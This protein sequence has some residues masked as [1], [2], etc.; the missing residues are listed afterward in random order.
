MEIF[1]SARRRLAAWEEQRPAQPSSEPDEPL[2]HEL[3]EPFRRLE[4]SGAPGFRAGLAGPLL[5]ELARQLAPPKH[6]FP[7]EEVH[8]AAP[9]LPDMVPPLE[10]I[11]VA[12]AG[13]RVRLRLDQAIAVRAW[14][15]GFEGGEP[16]LPEHL[17][18]RWR[19]L[20]LQRFGG[21][22]GFL[23]RMR[24][25][26]ASR[27]P[28]LVP[29]EIGGAFEQLVL[30]ILNEDAPLAHHASFEEDLYEKTDLR[31]KL[32]NLDR[33]R[34]ARVQVTLMSEPE[35]L[36]EK[37]RRIPRVRELVVLSPLTLAQAAIWQS[38]TKLLPKDE[39]AAFWACAPRGTEPLPL[40]R[41]LKQRLLAATTAPAAPEGPRAH[42]PEPI[43]RLLR[44][45]VANEATRSSAEMRE[46]MAS[47]RPRPPGSTDG[48]EG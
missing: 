42:V 40:A 12:H 11:T 9:A 21:G 2:P 10:A 32:P 33:R 22:L 48:G 35:K 14:S 23:A 34:G 20:V 45:Y 13:R 25:P 24:P 27:T 18:A 39:A 44:R 3:E 17:D 16:G 6:L 37:L 1:E 36:G 7:I 8:R 46:R 43:R 47:A 5:E 41:F 29:D 30:D 15:I 38:G 31:I 4:A 19:H 26:K 28:Q